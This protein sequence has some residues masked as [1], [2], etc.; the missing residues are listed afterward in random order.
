MSNSVNAREIEAFNRF[1]E[2]KLTALMIPVLQNGDYLRFLR[3]KPD[4]AKWIE[5]SMRWDFEFNMYPELS[6]IHAFKGGEEEVVMLDTRLPWY[7]FRERDLGFVKEYF[8]RLMYIALT[9]SKSEFYFLKM[10]LGNDVFEFIKRV[11]F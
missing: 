9:R 3:L 7:F 1:S 11:N 6:T 10:P 2:V 4:W 5:L 8:A